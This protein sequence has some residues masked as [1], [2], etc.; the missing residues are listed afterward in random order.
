MHHTRRLTDML[1]EDNSAFARAHAVHDPEV[2]VFDG[3]RPGE[4]HHIQ[5]LD[6]L[7]SV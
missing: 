5:H 2:D 7:R 1:E 3:R 6:K 4:F